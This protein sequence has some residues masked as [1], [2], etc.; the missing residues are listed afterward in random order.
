[1]TY[2]DKQGTK[3][4]RTSLNFN[5][6]E[7]TEGDSMQEK[8][9]F[10]PIYGPWGTHPC[11]NIHTVNPQISSLGGL[12]IFEFLHGGLFEVEFTPGRKFKNFPGSWSYSS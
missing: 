7:L 5:A 1:M 8:A 2:I 11:G 3:F 10:I 6:L 12:F 9:K 4:H